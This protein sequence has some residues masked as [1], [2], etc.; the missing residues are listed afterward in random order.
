M[1][2][3]RAR[4]SSVVEYISRMCKACDLILR[5]I[6]IFSGIAKELV[7]GRSTCPVICPVRVMQRNKLPQKLDTFKFS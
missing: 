7:L 5:T 3:G 2:I 6:R 4:G 1:A